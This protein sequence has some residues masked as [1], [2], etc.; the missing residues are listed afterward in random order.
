MTALSPNAVVD[1]IGKPY[2]RGGRGPDTYD[3]AG[4]VV[5]IL[6][7]RGISL[8]IPETPESNADQLASMREI[9]H[10]RWTDVPRAVPGCLVYFKGLPGHVGIMLSSYDFIHVAEDVAQ[11]C[12]ERLEGPIWPRRFAGFYAYCRGAAGGAQ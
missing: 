6:R 8:A 9:L 3:C 12:I 1:L 11:V 4:L 2:A 10:A 7:R 5:E